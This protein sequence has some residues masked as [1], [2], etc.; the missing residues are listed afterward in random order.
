MYKSLNEL[1]NTR[2]LKNR[3]NLTSVKNNGILFSVNLDDDEFT[4]FVLCIYIFKFFL[5]LLFS[6]IIL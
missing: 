4:I 1:S 2:Y 5:S 3:F 6:Q